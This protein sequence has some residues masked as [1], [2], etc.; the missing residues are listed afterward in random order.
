M[1]NNVVITTRVVRTEKTEEVRDCL[2]QKLIRY[3][4]ELGYVPF[5]IPNFEDVASVEKFMN[6]IK[7]SLIV[8]SGGNNI[9]PAL[10]GSTRTDILDVAVT[11]DRTEQELL[12][13]ASQRNLKVIGICRGMQMINVFFGGKLSIIKN[14]IASPC[15]HVAVTHPITIDKINF[16]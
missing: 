9:A 5:L 10:Y 16:M 13:M 15:N 1:N 14:E 11:R 3:F 8:L 4:E 6:I 12:R 7:P 2:D